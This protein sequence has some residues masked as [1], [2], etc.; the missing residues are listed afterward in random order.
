MNYTM[1]SQVLPSGNQPEEIDAMSV[2]RAFESIPDH[3]RKRGVRYPLALILTLVVLGKLAGMTSL[4]A[5]G[6]WV[7]LREEWLNHVLPKLHKSFPCA[8][9]Y[10]NVLQ[11]MKAE[12]VNQVMSQ[13]LTGVRARERCADEPSR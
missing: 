13:W 3:R 8:A 4:A 1:M 9:T 6:E 2:Y 12:E 5:V 7:R 10:S 11:A